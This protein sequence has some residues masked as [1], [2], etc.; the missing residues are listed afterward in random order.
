MDQGIPETPPEVG[1]VRPYPRWGREQVTGASPGGTPVPPM[2]KL[3]R[4][5]NQER[6]WRQATDYLCTY[7]NCKRDNKY[8][9]YEKYGKY[10]KL[11]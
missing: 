1:G 2:H 9:E 7:K 8:Q 10:G 11:L 6:I 4:S 5:K 3:F